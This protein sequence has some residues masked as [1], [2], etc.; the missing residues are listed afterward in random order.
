M[1][2]V[3]NRYE[4]LEDMFS[5]AGDNLLEANLPTDVFSG[6][7]FSMCLTRND[8]LRMINNLTDKMREERA[9]VSKGDMIEILNIEYECGNISYVEFQVYFKPHLDAKGY[10]VIQ[11]PYGWNYI[12]E[13]FLKKVPKVKKDKA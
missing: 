2:K 8:I 4:V 1:L 12:R 10:H 11:N 9:K 6:M 13:E 7:N 3:G 5:A